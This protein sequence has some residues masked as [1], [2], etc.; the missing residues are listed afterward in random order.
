MKIKEAD[1]FMLA[2]IVTF[3]QVLSFKFIY[4]I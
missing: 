1:I 2:P 4:F 3:Q